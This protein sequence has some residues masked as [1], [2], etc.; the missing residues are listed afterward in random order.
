MYLIL[1]TIL[2]QTVSVK[3]YDNYAA[4]HL[5]FVNHAEKTIAGLEQQVKDA[6]AK[7]EAAEKQVLHIYFGIIQQKKLLHQVL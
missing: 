1:L 3:T 7:I 5:A 2:C 6:E 4:Q